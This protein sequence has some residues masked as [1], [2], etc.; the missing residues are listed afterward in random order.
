MENDA[1]Y[2][3]PNIPGDDL[4][5]H[6]AED[7]VGLELAHRLPHRRTSGSCGYTDLVFQG[8]ERDVSVL[9]QTIV[10]AGKKQNAH[11]HTSSIYR[12]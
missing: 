5:Q 2:R 1:G 12:R 3:F 8:L 4:G 10:S 6:G 9:G 7:Q 11:D